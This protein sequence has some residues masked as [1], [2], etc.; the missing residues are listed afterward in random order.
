MKVSEMGDEL[1]G[2]LIEIEYMA[3]DLAYLK[4]S[5][6]R[7]PAQSDIQALGSKLAEA[8][9]LIQNAVDDGRPTGMTDSLLPAQSNRNR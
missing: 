6:G 7:S 3:A 1:G 5:L 2:I 8:A 9:R 4:L